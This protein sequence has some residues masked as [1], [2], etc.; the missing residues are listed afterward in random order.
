MT[1]KAVRRLAVTALWTALSLSTARA[2]SNRWTRGT[3]D[4]GPENA[5]AVWASA[6]Q[7]GLVLAAAVNGLFRSDDGGSHWRPLSV[8]SSVWGLA[9]DPRDDSH[10]YAYFSEAGGVQQS[11][12]GGLTWKPAN[13]GLPPWGQTG[14]SSLMIQ[15]S[16]P[17]TLFIEA[18]FDL[19]RS[20]DSGATW[21]PVLAGQGVLG[22]RADP[23]SGALYAWS[24]SSVVRSLDGGDHWLPASAGIPVASFSSVAVS[25][26][27]RV[28]AV[29]DGRLFGSSDGGSRWTELF[30]D[31]GR[32]FEV[33]S[34]PLP[35]GPLYVIA[36]GTSG[37]NPVGRSRD[38]GT[39][40]VSVTV[41]QPDPY[42]NAICF[43]Q[44]PS[45]VFAAGNTV[46]RS[47]TDGDIWQKSATPSSTVAG[48][49]VR[50][51][52]AEPTVVYAAGGTNRLSRSDDAGEHW[53]RIDAGLGTSGSLVSAITP[54]PEPGSVLAATG[55]G[56]YDSVTAGGIWSALS[57]IPYL[58][59][60]SI[61]SREPRN[62]SALEAECSGY[63]C[64]LWP[65]R[66]DDEGRT[67]AKIEVPQ[68]VTGLTGIVDP[69][70]DPDKLC[71]FDGNGKLFLGPL[72][73]PLLES[74]DAPV[75]SELAADPNAPGTLFSLVYDSESHVFLSTDAGSSWTSQ[76]SR[77]LPAYVRLLSVAPNGSLYAASTEV[78]Y[79]SDDRGRT[80][81]SLPSD[82]LEDPAIRSIAA[83]ADGE[84]VF[85]GTDNAV[86][87]LTYCARCLRVASARPD[88][89]PVARPASPAQ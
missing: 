10:V 44:R 51:S 76:S 19:Y 33:F 54:R 75:L 73:G 4:W 27:G 16:A 79:R 87:Q 12:D 80:W 65:Y 59:Q 52:P 72:S 37:G 83:S 14:P 70:S 24:L 42:L 50:T 22:V 43:S 23:R 74:P 32:L 88:T 39:S 7:P 11:R 26:S 53:L 68:S 2:G 61:N 77:G 48:T 49:L 85:A 6:R 41:D 9:V 81:F 30:P 18:L 58:D 21:S 1:R 67:W 57:S 89:R 3:P 69:G 45:E 47:D 64:Y 63:S 71:A 34:S 56:L 46:Y 60:I 82:G 20:V 36:F 28:F 55:D 35:G 40:W 25:A 38:G 62:L 8:K 13:T 29:A 5:N 15:P 66:S 78:V 31:L 84:T 17:D 86:Y